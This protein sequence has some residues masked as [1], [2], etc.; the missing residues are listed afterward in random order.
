MRL[1]LITIL[2]MVAFAANS[3]LNRSAVASFDTGPEAFAVIR[4]IAGAVTLMLLLA[5]R[6]QGR[7]FGAWS[8]RLPG[9]AMLALY[10]AGFSLAYRSL[11]AGIGA[12]ILFGGVQITMFAGAFVGRE[13]IPTWRWIGAGVSMTGLLVLVWPSGG[14][15]PSLAGALLM[16][17]AAVGWGFY[18]LLG[19]KVSDPLAATAWNFLLAV[20]LVAPLA[21]LG[22][23]GTAAG[24]GLAVVSGAVT[25]GL[26]YALW[27]KI[28][29]QLGATRAAVAQL[30]VPVIATLGGVLLLSEPA[31]LR[32]AIATCLVLGGI[33]VSLRRP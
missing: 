16:A 21:L 29:P 17:A 15:A 23:S 10:M 20:P 28:V 7:A 12:L 9:A 27:Y 18:S 22:L 11:E 30:S 3:V 14:S 19:R 13:P 8:Q 24:Y 1:L 31:S 33:A 2:T 5:L 32:L 25:S 6:G 4:T 26:G